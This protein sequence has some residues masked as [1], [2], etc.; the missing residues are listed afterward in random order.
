MPKHMP[1]VDFWDNWGEAGEYYEDTYVPDVEEVAI[2][3]DNVSGGNA[4]YDTTAT[5]DASDV[6]S[7]IGG[8]TTATETIDT[9]T[10][11]PI[12]TSTIGPDIS[13]GDVA[14]EGDVVTDKVAPII[15][16]G[17]RKDY[18]VPG[19]PAWYI[20]TEAGMLPEQEWLAKGGSAAE[21]VTAKQEEF[22]L[23]E[24]MALPEGFEHLQEAINAFNF[25]GVYSEE[26]EAEFVELLQQ[27]S[28][29][30]LATG[31]GGIGIPAI[32][33]PAMD[34]KTGPTGGFSTGGFSIGTQ[35]MSEEQALE[36]ASSRFISK[37]GAEQVADVKAG[38]V[39]ADVAEPVRTQAQLDLMA[40][41]G[42]S[43]D[44]I[45]GREELQSLLSQGIATGEGHRTDEDYF[46]K[47]AKAIARP[48][49]MPPGYEIDADTLSRTGIAEV[50]FV[51]SPSGAVADPAKRFSD[52]PNIE[53]N[54]RREASAYFQARYNAQQELERYLTSKYQLRIKL[55]DP[56]VAA[57]AAE[58]EYKYA[59]MN[60][61]IELS[62]TQ[63]R[64]QAEQFQQTMLSMAG[65]ILFSKS[66]AEAA[67]LDVSGWK[68]SQAYQAY[69]TIEK[70]LFNLNEEIRVAELT[71]VYGADGAETLAARKMR[72]DQEARQLLDLQSEANRRTQNTGTV[73][74][75]V[76]SEQIPIYGQDPTLQAGERPQTWEIKQS[77]DS[78]NK[79][80]P[81][82]RGEELALEKAK[83]DVSKDMAIMSE[84]VNYWEIAAKR[85]ADTGL[86]WE[87]TETEVLDEQGNVI[88]MAFGLVRTGFD[89]TDIKKVEMQRTL[90]NIKDQTARYEAD[91]TKTIAEIKLQHQREGEWAQLAEHKAIAQI[92]ADAKTTVAQK[93]LEAAQAGKDTEIAILTKRI[94]LENQRAGQAITNQQAMLEATM[95]KE[96][97]LITAKILQE[98]EML[99]MEIDIRTAEAL[100]VE[101]TRKQIA[102]IQSRNALDAIIKKLDADKAAAKLAFIQ[103]Y[104]L[105]PD[106]VIEGGILGVESVARVA[107]AKSLEELETTELGVREEKATEEIAAREKTSAELAEEM[108]AA[109]REALAIDISAGTDLAVDKTAALTFTTGLNTAI[110]NAKASGDYASVEAALSVPLPP[111]PSGVFWDSSSG[112]FQQRSGFQGR[113]MTASVQK[114]IANM[115]PAFKAR[116]R[117]EQATREAT[118]IQAEMF[119]R[120]EEKRQADADFRLY[121]T[122]GDIDSAEE[123]IA[124]QR[125]AETAQIAVQT[126]LEHLQ[127]L[128]SLLQNPVQL[129]MAKKYGLLGQI[130]AVLGFTMANVPEAPAAGAGVPTVNQWQTMDSENQAFSLAAYVEQGGTPDEFMRMIAGSAPAQ[131]QQVTYGVL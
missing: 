3:T 126:K 28:T 76:P 93:Q 40:L 79:P 102:D 62:D 55:N 98:Q 31:K 59:A 60:K 83:L 119:T 8:T 82:I 66:Q 37:F 48:M 95:T 109:E 131:M 22:G 19:D 89:S 9:V 67:G 97:E 7:L 116:D 112:S 105:D 43:E 106:A 2:S 69:D 96:I 115:A 123:A 118:R 108:R 63:E 53:A 87:V 24:P 84:R 91:M 45:T 92:A 23:L 35:G 128:F 77:L 103:K 117:A 65:S 52:D 42:S 86:V 51:P 10:P 30:T 121:M 39:E 47:L 38:V 33:I 36:Y 25:G 1:N 6:F 41:G 104:G 81:S 49:T 129:G 94:E 85:T 80:I 110:E 114:W 74:E 122:T 125:M 61:N 32:G 64:E 127:M 20:M 100:A 21:F 58:L 56:A 13:G 16:V 70:Q 75:V 44:F 34:I 120:V 101:V 26:R 90:A 46:D 124:R 5:A 130:E 111:A 12:K 78:Q 73:W 50:K 54:W 17:T 72:L 57:A 18:G 15:P 11:T 71:G 14:I 113:E 88:D 29:M 99:Q 107:E 27:G 68:E 4:L